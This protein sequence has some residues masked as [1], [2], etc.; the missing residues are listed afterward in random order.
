MG[1]KL[2]YYKIMIYYILDVYVGV[3]YLTIRLREGRFGDA[4]QDCCE[5]MWLL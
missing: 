2:H 5:E 4:A 3:T 1:Q